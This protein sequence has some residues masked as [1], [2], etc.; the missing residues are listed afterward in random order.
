VDR[1][2]QR[3][4]WTWSGVCLVTVGLILG[5]EGWCGGLMARTRMR[6]RLGDAA[7]TAG[8]LS[9]ERHLLRPYWIRGATG[10]GLAFSGGTLLA[11]G[12]AIGT[13]G[14]RKDL[15]RKTSGYCDQCGYDLTATYL[16]TVRNAGTPLSRRGLGHQ[17]GKGR[18]AV[19]RPSEQTSKRGPRSPGERSIQPKRRCGRRIPKRSVQ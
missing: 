18:S 4:A 5:V 9:Y 19:R 13:L 2:R 16:D 11:L 10:I 7:V 14:F 1:A 17:E 3:G 15:L 8:Y 12:K 6:A